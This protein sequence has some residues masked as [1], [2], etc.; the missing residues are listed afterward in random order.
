[1]KEPNPGQLVY[2]FTKEEALKFVLEE[3]E[4]AAEL[5]VQLTVTV[6]NL[7]RQVN[8]LTARVEELERQLSQ[9]SSNSSKP[10]SSDGYKKPSPRS[11]RKKA[12]K[13]KGGQKGHPGSTLKMVENPDEIIVHETDVCS[14]GKLVEEGVIIA[15]QR[16]QVFDVP[17]ISLKVVEHRIRTTACSC[18]AIHTGAFP[19][20]VRAPVQ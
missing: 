18:G 15:E 16:R 9:N 4:K 5:L 13:K 10:P 8:L 11:L 12:G 14:C 17:K 19:Y 20:G 3:P 6:N 1:M 2:E 7:A